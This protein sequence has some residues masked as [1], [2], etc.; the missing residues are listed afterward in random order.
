MQNVVI[1]KQIEKHAGGMG[2]ICALAHLFI[3]STAFFNYKQTRRLAVA[4]SYFSWHRSPIKG[5]LF[6]FGV[7]SNKNPTDYEMLANF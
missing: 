5:S 3:G 7:M 2:A 4:H 6:V 1:F